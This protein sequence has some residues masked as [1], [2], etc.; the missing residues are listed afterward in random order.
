MRLVDGLHVHADE[1]ALTIEA[2]SVEVRFS[3]M[4][5]DAHQVCNLAD[6]RALG[7]RYACW[8]MTVLTARLRKYLQVMHRRQLL[9]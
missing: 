6:V 5:G 8:Q 2:G 4:L 3:L 9:E 1:V 7:S